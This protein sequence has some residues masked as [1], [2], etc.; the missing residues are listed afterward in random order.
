MIS[1]PVA[2]VGR[3]A[4]TRGRQNLCREEEVGGGLLVHGQLRSACLRH[5]PPSLL[6]QQAAPR[7]HSSDNSDD[8]STWSRKCPLELKSTCQTFMFVSVKGVCSGIGTCG[9]RFPGLERTFEQCCSHLVLTTPLLQIQGAPHLLRL[10]FS[11]APEWKRKRSLN[12]KSDSYLAAC[13][14][15]VWPEWPSSE[16]KRFRASPSGSTR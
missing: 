12:G 2:I 13:V 10:N 6:H 4:S 3:E 14:P 9:L 1:S 7:F 5:P 15:S 8:G 11:A 16:S